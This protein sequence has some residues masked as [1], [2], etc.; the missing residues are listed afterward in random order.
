[1]NYNETLTWNERFELA[2]A[3]YNHHGHLR[4]VASFKTKDGFT[5]DEEGFELGVWINRQRQQYRLKELTK[6]HYEK[7]NSIGMVF[8]NINEL[9][10]ETLYTLTQIYYEYYGNLFI[11]ADFKTTNGIERDESGKNLGAWLKAQRYYYNHKLLSEER[12]KKIGGLLKKVEDDKKEQAKNDEIE[13]ENMYG[14]ATI[15]YQKYG[16]LTLPNKFITVNGYE[17]DKEGDDLGSW[18]RNQRT[19]YKRKRLS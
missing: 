11:P 5:Y 16:H 2:K 14:L 15:Y 17:K 3:F 10:W 8:D 19:L 7:L 12:H 13:W 4:V 9:D 18:V 6:E 1:M